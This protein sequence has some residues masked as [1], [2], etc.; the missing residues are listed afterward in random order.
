MVPMAS[1]EAVHGGM[2]D[3]EIQA[4]KPRPSYCFCYLVPLKRSPRL[5]CRRIIFITL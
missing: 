1:I 3:D 4:P 2:G 5:L